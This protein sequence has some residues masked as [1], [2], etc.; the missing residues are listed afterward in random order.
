MSIL[1][2]HL[3]IVLIAA[4]GG[5]MLNV[6]NLWDDSHKAKPDRISKDFLYCSFFVIWPIV[7]GILAWIYLLDGSTLR[8]I[9]ALSIGLGA[10]AT[11]KSLA[12]AATRK[13]DPPIAAE[14]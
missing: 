10:P 12:A 3:D 14:V 8:P 4:F 9:L 6:V 7:A 5:L 2:A 13:A 11:L 1:L